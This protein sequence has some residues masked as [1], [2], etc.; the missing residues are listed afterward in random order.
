MLRFVARLSLGG[1]LALFALTLISFYSTSSAQQRNIGLIPKLTAAS[2]FFWLPQVVTP[3]TI[4][5]F[6]ADCETPE[7]VY[8]LGETVC[9]VS[10]NAPPPSFGFRQRRFQWVTPNGTVVQQTEITTNPQSDSYTIPTAGPEA[11][12][13]TWSVRSIN[14]RGGIATIAKFT[15]RDP[16]NLRTDLAVGKVGPLEVK[17]GNNVSYSITLVNRGPDDAQNVQ[18][19]DAVPANMTFVA[20]TQASGASFNCTHPSSGGTGTSVCTIAT[21]PRNSTATFTFIYQVDSGTATGTTIENTVNVSSSTVELNPA[22]NSFTSPVTVTGAG[23]GGGECVISCPADITV[24]H[25]T[26]VAGATVTYPA[27]TTTGSNCG[28]VSSSPASGTFF[29]VGTTTVIASA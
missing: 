28:A 4:D 17:S 11:Q 14:N 5:T 12:I 7:N 21:L 19:T 27:P 22:D 9:A 18:L 25:E 8:V 16:N 15:V 29:P 24:P 2:S 26:G 23:S 1:A 10:T 20:G 6:E 3:E 13:G